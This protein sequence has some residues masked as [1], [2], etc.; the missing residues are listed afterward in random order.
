MWGDSRDQILGWPM[1]SPSEPLT[2]L[3]SDLCPSGLKKT[4][5]GKAAPMPVPWMQ[6]TF[7]PPGA[8]IL[9]P[10]AEHWIAYTDSSANDSTCV[11]TVSIPGGKMINFILQIKALS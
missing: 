7:L 1:S 3:H 9:Y 4:S 8:F 2:E 6:Y 5:E 10:G 11:L